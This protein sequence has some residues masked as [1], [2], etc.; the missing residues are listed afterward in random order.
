MVQTKSLSYSGRFIWVYVFTFNVLCL[1]CGVRDNGVGENVNGTQRGKEPCTHKYSPCCCWRIW[2]SDSSQVLQET[3]CLCIVLDVCSLAGFGWI[4]NLEF[5]D[6][7]IRF[8][9]SS[10]FQC[11]GPPL[12]LNVPLLVCNFMWT[13]PAL[14]SI[15]KA[16]QCCFHRVRKPLVLT[17]GEAGDSL[18]LNHGIAL[19]VL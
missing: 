8:L 12:V 7:I 1:N 9:Y 6:Y 14:L 17:N 4:G 15:H 10:K 11:S 18:K 2:S 5:A 13:G 16:V 3:H 19:V